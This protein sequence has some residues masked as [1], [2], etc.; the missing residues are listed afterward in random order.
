MCGKLIATNLQK[1]RRFFH[2]QHQLGEFAMV[3]RFSD[4]YAFF[5]KLGAVL[6][7][8]RK[9]PPVRRI[10]RRHFRIKLLLHAGIG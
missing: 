3:V 8:V 2:G 1:S 9:A 7:E 10:F 6:S 5:F 4:G